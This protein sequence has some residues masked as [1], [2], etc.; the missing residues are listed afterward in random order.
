MLASTEADASRSDAGLRHPLRAQALGRPPT[1]ILVVDAHFL[2]REALRDAL[3]RMPGEVTV[4]E[5]TDG[6]QA[7]Q[8]A[9]EQSEIDLVLLE[10]DLPDRD[11]LSLLGE[12]RQHHPAMKV[13]MLSARHDGDSVASSLALGAAGFIPKSGPREIMLSA[14]ELVLAGGLYIPPEILLR[15]L[16]TP[17]RPN[18]TRLRTGA[19][20]MTPADLGLSGRQIDVLQLVMR[21]MSNKA[22]CRALSL[23]EPTVK[24]HVT[25]IL[26]ILKVSNRTEAVIAVGE[27]SLTWPSSRQSGMPR[28]A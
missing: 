9:S 25:A 19:R 8:L 27:L 3:K 24:N 26:K 20:G 2:I 14:L 17:H 22:I 1:M 6:R 12:L 4:I 23:A 11:G 16:V 21:G 15:E 28:V 13:V 7:L 5:A 10:L 18:I